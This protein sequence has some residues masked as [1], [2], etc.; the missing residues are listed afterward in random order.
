MGCNPLLNGNNKMLLIKHDKGAYY[1]PGISYN[2]F[3]NNG[4]AVVE[5]YDRDGRKLRDI[6]FETNEIEVIEV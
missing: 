1:T 4:E 5:T 3:R 6:K 2:V